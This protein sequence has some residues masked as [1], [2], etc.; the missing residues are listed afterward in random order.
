MITT[1]TTR[2]TTS[3]S[4]GIDRTRS[5]DG[6]ESRSSRSSTTGKNGLRK[7]G[8]NQRPSA[9]NAPKRA[10]VVGGIVSECCMMRIQSTTPATPTI[11]PIVAL[12]AVAGNV[13]TAIVINFTRWIEGS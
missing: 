5:T 9:K 8:A 2:I 3:Q 4:G 6:T 1:P 7:A 10:A 13:D 12:A 11:A